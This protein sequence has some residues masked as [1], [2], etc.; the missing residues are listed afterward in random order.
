MFLNGSSIFEAALAPTEP[1]P[2][3][4]ADAP[5]PLDGRRA[6]FSL[7]WVLALS[8]SDGWVDWSVGSSFGLV[9]VT[10]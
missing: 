3:L 2:E 1:F 6:M 7:L 8:M 5:S 9:G 10:G 4:L